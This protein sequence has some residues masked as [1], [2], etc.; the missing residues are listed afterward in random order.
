MVVADGART[1]IVAHYRVLNRP[2]GR[3][4]WLRL[5]GLDPSRTYRV[6]SWPEPAPTPIRRGGDDLMG[7]GLALAAPSAADGDFTARVFVLESEEA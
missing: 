4:G 7:A 2:T 5:R 6:S 1:A 3:A